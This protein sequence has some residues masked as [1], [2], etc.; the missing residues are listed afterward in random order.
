MLDNLNLEIF[1]LENE[2]MKKVEIESNE[3]LVHY[4]VVFPKSFI[5]ISDV[6]E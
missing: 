4:T 6:E 2:K 1:F 5:Q 3:W